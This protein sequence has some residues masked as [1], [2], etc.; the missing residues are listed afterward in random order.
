MGWEQ[1]SCSE[2][3]SWER[4]AQSEDAPVVLT[5][6]GVGGFCT[7]TVGRILGWTPTTMAL[8][9]QIRG[10]LSIIPF[11][12]PQLCP[13]WDEGILFVHCLHAHI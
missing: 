7:L 5:E 10:A 6:A 1:R 12:N 3:L 8:A 2:G 13:L 9:P 4:E 11:L